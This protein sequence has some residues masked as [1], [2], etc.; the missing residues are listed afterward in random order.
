MIQQ[1]QI[2]TVEQLQPLIDEMLSE[3]DEQAIIQRH[4]R[5]IA[6]ILDK[7]P[8]YY[9][10]YGVYWWALKALMIEHGANLGDEREEVT[11]EH[12]DYE[13][14]VALLAAAWAYSQD[15]IESGNINTTIHTYWIGE[16]ETMEYALEDMDMEA[17]RINQSK[18]F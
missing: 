5:S 16:D 17:R 10:N 7:T 13:N 14:K 9:R 8:E 11:R 6:G 15:V 12:C 1:I 4:V 3:L 18:S 2:P